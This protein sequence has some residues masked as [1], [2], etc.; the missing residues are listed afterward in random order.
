ME[1]NKNTFT[2]P[3]VPGEG[4]QPIA[5]IA[6]L[7]QSMAKMQH[8]DEVFFWLASAIAQNL[9][10]PVVQFW[11]NQQNSQGQSHGELRALACQNPSLPQQVYAN[12]QIKASVERLFHE[13]RN[14][15][16][17]PVE[18]IFS[19]SQASLLSQYHLRYWTGYFLRNEAL[20]PSA[21]IGSTPEKS[22]APFTMIIAFFTPAPLS[23][24]QIRATSF[25]LE[26]M[27]RIIIN[28]GFLTPPSNVPREASRGIPGKGISLTSIIP[29]RTEDIEQLQA[30]N[31]FAHASV[32]SN[33][34]ARRLYAAIDGSKSMAQL[35]QSARLE[36]KDF[37]EALRYLFQQQKIQFYTAE[38]EH[39]RH[40]STID[41]LLQGSL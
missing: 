24:E 38:G 34:N 13:R 25:I 31:P 12:I 8:V 35:I 10:I 6:Q 26:Q 15:A 18:S 39:I 14:I 28:R 9:N 3:S 27:M 19:S 17:S 29:H 23:S 11:A 7:M 16:S 40:P 22:F 41:S 20:L 36:Q 21:K 32:I 37:L 1:G 33:K 2:P 4:K 5:L 30:D